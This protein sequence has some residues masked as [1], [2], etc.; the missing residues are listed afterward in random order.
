[1]NIG[2]WKNVGKLCYANMLVHTL[3]RPKPTVMEFQYDPRSIVL[4]IN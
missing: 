3:I 2:K 4:F 1:M